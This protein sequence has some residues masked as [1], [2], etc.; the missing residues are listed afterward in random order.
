MIVYIYLGKVL[1][2]ISWNISTTTKMKKLTLL[3][4][5]D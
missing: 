5:A 1:E 4:Y 2:N 3:E